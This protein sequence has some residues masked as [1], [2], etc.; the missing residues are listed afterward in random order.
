MRCGK[1]FAPLFALLCAGFPAAAAQGEVRISVQKVADGL[2]M[3]VGRGGN[4]AISTGADGPLIVDD[5]FAPLAP[6]IEAAVRE[7]QDAPLRFVL[8]TH[9]HGDHTGGNEIFGGKGALIAAHHNVRARLSAKQFSSV[10]ERETPAAPDAALPVLTFEDGMTLHWNGEEIEVQHAARAHTDGDSIVWFR[11]AN[12]VH[13]GDLY[14][15]GLW[16]FIDVDSGGSLDG[17]IAALGEALTRLNRRSKV[18]PGHGPLSN[19]RE[20]RA[21]H[22]MLMELRA[23]VK[24]AIAEGADAE[25]LS[26]S[27]VADDLEERWGGG[28]LDTATFLRILHADL[29]R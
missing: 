20:L 9:W 13:L 28:F 26:R 1:L 19:R 8:N 12:A 7:I 5:Q 27:G 24:R 22:K 14:F 25:A 15:N 10:F 23:R 6:K 11:R 2:H 4:I 3:L 17:T 18:I 16:P 29:S 21:Y